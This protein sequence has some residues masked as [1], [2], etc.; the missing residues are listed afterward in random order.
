MDYDV[1]DCIE[2]VSESMRNY[3]KMCTVSS[4]HI[5]HLQCI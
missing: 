5:A 4:E 1:T 2:F 3:S